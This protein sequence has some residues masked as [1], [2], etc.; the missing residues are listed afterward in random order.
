M[1]KVIK[2]PFYVLGAILVG[3][4]LMIVGTVRVL[5]KKAKVKDSVIVKA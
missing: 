2:L 3:T 5:T 1:D 4:G